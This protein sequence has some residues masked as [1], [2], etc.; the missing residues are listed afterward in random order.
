[1]VLHYL[2]YLYMIHGYPH[3]FTTTSAQPPCEADEFKLPPPYTDPS[4]YPR[5]IYRI[6]DEDKTSSSRD[7]YDFSKLKQFPINVANT[8]EIYTPVLL[9]RFKQMLQF[10]HV[11]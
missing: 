6:L 10:K 7:A 9:V 3:W 4:N 5:L 8:M 1:M 2:A 11:N